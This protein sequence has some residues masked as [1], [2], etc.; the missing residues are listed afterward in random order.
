MIEIIAVSGLEQ[1]S[2]RKSSA[3]WTPILGSQI[4]SSGDCSTVG[5]GGERAPSGSQE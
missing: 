2:Q 1:R 3:R 5:S 4:I